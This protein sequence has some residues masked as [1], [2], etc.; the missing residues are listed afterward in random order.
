MATLPICSKCGA[1]SSGR[2]CASC[3]AALASAACEACLEPL[4]ADARFCPACGQARGGRQRENAAGGRIAWEWLVPG[5]ALMALVAFLI[6]QRLGR[7]DP[8]VAAVAAKMDGDE[9][10][11]A[12]SGA[13][14]GARAPDIS[15]MSPEERATRLFDRVMRYGEEG[16]Q[17][18][19]RIFAPMAIQAYEMLGPLDAHS[20]YDIGMIAVVSGN[21]ETARAQADS[22]LRKQPTHL[23]GLVL[24]M[25]AAGLQ[26]DTLLRAQFAKRLAAASPN[27]RSKNMKEYADHGADIDAALL[28]PVFAKKVI[29]KLSR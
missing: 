22:I 16:K 27:E 14:R 1:A 3:G 17:D 9:A 5:V 28:P 12:V 6:G 8:P 20:R 2:F 24:A 29:S 23:L 11:L 13:V 19:A 7:T 15:K 26:R 4:E 25:K 10:G 18:S 21:S